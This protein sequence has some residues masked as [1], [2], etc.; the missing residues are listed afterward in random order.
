MPKFSCRSVT[1]TRV[2][3]R[4]LLPSK[5]MTRYTHSLSLAPTCHPAVLVR[6]LSRDDG[7]CRNLEDPVLDKS[8]GGGPFL[9]DVATVT[10]ALARADVVVVR[11]AVT[12][13]CTLGV[14]AAIVQQGES[15]SVRLVVCLGRVVRLGASQVAEGKNCSCSREP[16]AYLSSMVSA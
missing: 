16:T 10:S 1:F 5:S 13:D 15:R 6:G 14:G 2:R 9:P 12:G 11:A 4:S 7:V 8:L 3:T